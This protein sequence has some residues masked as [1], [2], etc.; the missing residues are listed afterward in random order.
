M[1]VDVDETNVASGTTK[2]YDCQMYPYDKA[3]IE[4][5]KISGTDTATLKIYGSNDDTIPS[6]SA[7][8]IDLSQYGV[9]YV[10]NTPS[11]SGYTA[12]AGLIVND[13]WKFIRC[14]VVTT[15]GTGDSTYSIRVRGV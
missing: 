3:I 15:G 9:D 4:Y 10:N 8:M 14:E 2:Q 13:S 12:D 7:N 11:A 5:D 1:L 6:S